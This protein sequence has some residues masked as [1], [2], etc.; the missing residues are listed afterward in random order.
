[1][2]KMKKTAKIMW[3]VRAGVG[4]PNPAT[5]SGAVPGHHMALPVP[6]HSGRSDGHLLPDVFLR[7]E[8]IV[9]NQQIFQPRMLRTIWAKSL[10]QGHVIAA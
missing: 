10:T 3:L 8:I 1:M 4:G 5:G 7:S 6:A 2:G 9:S